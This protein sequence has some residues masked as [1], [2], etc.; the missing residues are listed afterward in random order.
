MDNLASITAIANFTMKDEGEARGEGKWYKERKEVRGST[1]KLTSPVV[2]CF[3]A[4]VYSQ[5][6]LFIKKKIKK[7][8]I[9]CFPN[10]FKWSH[11]I[12]LRTVV[13]CCLGTGVNMI[14]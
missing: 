2:C 12:I 14:Y 7:N 5:N 11:N 9:R 6:G 10:L 1:E 3:F 13:S 4:E 8:V